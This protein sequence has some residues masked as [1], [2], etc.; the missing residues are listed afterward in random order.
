MF[1]PRL[2]PDP[3]DRLPQLGVE[4][5]TLLLQPSTLRTVLLRELQQMRQQFLDFACEWSA[6]WPWG[7]RN[8]VTDDVPWVAVHLVTSFEIDLRRY[9]SSST[10]PFRPDPTLR[11]IFLFVLELCLS[12]ERSYNIT[13]TLKDRSLAHLDA[14][15]V[16]DGTTVYLVNAVGAI[17]TSVI[18]STLWRFMSSVP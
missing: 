13:H 11:S 3:L 1:G 16:T 7:A 9:S 17:D 18:T 5:T 8:N 10:V 2:F 6:T 4:R 15:D 12:I 14:L